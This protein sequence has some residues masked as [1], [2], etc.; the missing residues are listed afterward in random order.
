MEMEATNLTWVS[1]EELLDRDVK[2][3][4]C[5]VDP[6]LPKIGIACLAG[7]SDTGKSSLL[8]YLCMSIVSGKTNFLDFKINADR[9]KAIYVSTEDEEMSISYLLNRQNKDMQLE[10]SSLKDLR[11]MFDTTD[12][13][14]RLD[15]MMSENPVDLVCIDAIT[16][17]YN[18][19]MNDANK[20]R[21]FLNE[22]SQLARK[23]K[24]LILFLHHCAKG[25]EQFV[26]SKS[27]LLG[28]QAFEAKMRLVIELI[29]DHNNTRQKHLCIVKG[30]YLPD[31]S[32]RESYQ[33]TFS[34]N[35]TFE[36]TGERIPFENLTKNNDD[37]RQK[38][39]QVKEYQ[40]QGL[41]FQQIAEK[42]SYSNKSSISRLISKFEK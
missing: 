33:L 31:T 5:I 34:E 32:K 9:R 25:T 27:H 16:D 3:I 36:N 22:F 26:P 18:G 23:H 12:M 15:D 29:S 11:F 24:C 37:G 14:N 7:S 13:M 39:E 42:M 17:L 40:K 21:G 19:S 6:I 35:L 8:R 28:S 30:N 20:V 41:S 10:N 1:G 2:E 4:P 38:Y